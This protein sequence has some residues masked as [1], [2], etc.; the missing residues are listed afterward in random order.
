MTRYALSAQEE[1]MN[2]YEKAFNDVCDYLEAEYQAHREAAQRFPEHAE[3]WRGRQDQASNIRSHLRA[4]VLEHEA[5][6]AS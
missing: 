3:Y 1:A 5:V 4:K 6:A 2:T